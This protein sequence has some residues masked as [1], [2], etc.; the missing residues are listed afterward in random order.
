M[1]A[2]SIDMSS[3]VQSGYTGSLGGPGVGG[4]TGSNWFIAFGM[5]LAAT[6]GTPVLAAFDGHVTRF[7]PDRP[8]PPGAKGFGAE[9]FVR[10]ASD[11]MGG[12][13]T[14]ITDIPPS[15]LAGAKVSRG[16]TLGTVKKWPGG[17][18]HLHFALVEIIGG[19]PSGTYK[20]V[21]LMSTF[22]SLSN[23]TNVV[24]VTFNQDGT[25]PTVS[26]P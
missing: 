23:T 6:P 3:P 5:D 19:A 8:T 16:D 17:P 2:F 22:D 14:H 4:H 1:T 12:Y 20:G 11:K 13:Y 25:P 7:N 18:S 24:T 9:I 26:G 21:N 10:D 15:V